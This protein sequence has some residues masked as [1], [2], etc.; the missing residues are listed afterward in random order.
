M[1]SPRPWGWSVLAQSH[2]HS[3]TVFPTPVGMVRF[4]AQVNAAKVGFPHA[5][6]DGPVYRSTTYGFTPFSPRPWGWSAHYRA[7]D[8]LLG[9][10]PT[11]VGMVRTRKASRA[12]TKRFPHARGDGPH[13]ANSA[14]N[15][16]SFSPR[17]WGWS[18]L[19]ASNKLPTDV[20]PTPVGMVRTRGS[21]C[22]RRGSFPHA[23]GDGPVPPAKRGS[24][25]E[26]SPRPWGWSGAG[27]LPL[28]RYRVFPTPV[29][30]VRLT[31]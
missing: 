4:I 8:R 18:A 16:R 12:C 5:R 23:R 13:S 6:G 21:P 20:F 3:W 26:F 31:A 19:N 28:Y 9:V 30:M 27:N 25:R 11:P 15:S 22:R 7:F 10:F 14:S 29:G 2:G 1:F 17:P 24:L